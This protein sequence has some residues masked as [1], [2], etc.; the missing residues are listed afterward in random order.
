M[1]LGIKGKR[2]L[3]GGAVWWLSLGAAASCSEHHESDDDDDSSGQAGERATGGSSSAKGG[4]SS[5]TTGG[6]NAGATAGNG[7]GAT[8]SGGTDSGAGQGNA[9]GGSSPG[10]EGSGASGGSNPAAG[11]TQ[12][13]IAGAG[14]AEDCPDT[15]CPVCGDKL[16]EGNEACDDGN[17]L[18]FDGCSPT[19]TIEPACDGASC[20][21]T[22][23]DG[24]LV[25]GEECDDGN[26]KDGDGCSADCKVEKG[27]SCAPDTCEKL[28]GQCV[29][30]LPIVF[31]DFNASTSTNGH[32]DFEPGVNSA[33]VVQGLVLPEL[34]SDGKP[35]LSG[36]ASASVAGGFMHGVSAFAQWYRDNPPASKPIPSEIVLWD[37]GKGGFVNRWGAK[38]EQWAGQALT[39]YCG[40]TPDCSGCTNTALLACTAC[41]DVPGYYCLLDQSNY[42]GNPLF[43]PIDTAPGILNDTRLK[44]KVPEQYGWPGWPWE[45]YVADQLNVTTPVATATAPFPTETHN[46]SFTTEL[47]F[48]FRYDETKTQVL[49]FTGD[50]DVWLFVNGHLA[51]DLGGW[52]VP[53]DA[54][55]TI[56]GGTVTSVASL[57]ATTHATKNGTVADYGLENGKIYQIAVFHAERQSEG[58]SFKLDISGLDATPSN[59][60][61]N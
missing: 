55:V 58:S 56:A 38:G 19:C 39:T 36:T 57:T 11:G 8:G 28:N 9:A 52:H 24:L 37:D 48:W 6:K 40:T 12:S 18:P 32:P 15:G 46:F 34:D 4:K 51:G 53:L 43:F 35:V 5:G 7:S 10:G 16:V 3:F 21:G 2:L 44:A 1:A 26:T 13:A 45:Y 20:A 49:S 60:V 47:K 33:G 54:T 50:D 17:T 41:P 59:C 61:K 42:D 30:R 29:V 14:G 27:Y 31:R 22:C 23:G 25:S